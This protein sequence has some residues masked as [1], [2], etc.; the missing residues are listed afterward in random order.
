MTVIHPTAIVEPGAQLGADCEVQAYAVVK[1]WAVL[2]DRVQV[3]H[4]AAVGGN[5]Q[6]LKFNPATPSGARIGAGTRIREY[7]TVH[8]ATHENG[9]TEI[10]ENCLLMAGAHVA[11]D[12]VVG[13]NVVIANAVLLAGHVTVGDNAILGGGSGFHQFI[14][15]GEGTMVGGGASITRDIPPFTLAADRDDA[16]GLNLIGLK[17]R[18]APAESIRQLKEAF[19]RVYLIPGN[20][21]ELAAAALAEGGFEAPE[22]RRFLEFFSGGT[23]GFTRPRRR[24]QG[25]GDGDE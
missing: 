5:S 1:Q 19:R 22:A 16:V 4:F 6:D 7:V 17:R 15:V 18:G 21:R 13:R 23:R 24:K 2:G 20:V 9:F 8:R 12:C 3:H 25:D 11:H 10:G 14:R